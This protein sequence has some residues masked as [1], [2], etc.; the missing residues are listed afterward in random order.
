[1]VIITIHSNILKF[2]EEMKIKLIANENVFF[3]LSFFLIYFSKLQKVR[4]DHK[5]RNTS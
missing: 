3:F 4:C 1:M 5:F 2:R